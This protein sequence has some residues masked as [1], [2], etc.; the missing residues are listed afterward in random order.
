MA[1][2]KFSVAALRKVRKY[3]NN[4]LA[5]PESEQQLTSPLVNDDI[6]VPEP[7]SLDAL[8]DVF[9]FGGFDA[10]EDGEAI[11]PEGR[12]LISVVNP[13]EVLVKLPNLQL[14][15]GYR[16]VSYLFRAP[17]TG[18]GVMWAVP[19]AEGTT[20]QLEAALMAADGANRPPR[21]SMALVDVMAVV[22]GDRSPSSFLIASILKR[23]FAE[24]GAQGLA[25]DWS[26]HELIDNI[27]AR[28]ETYWRDD[29]PRDLT[30][31]IRSSSDGQ[32]VVEFFSCRTKAPVEI[33]RHIDQYPAHEDASPPYC[34][35][36]DRQVVL[37]LKSR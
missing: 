35:Q 24:F 8:G 27:P 13:A 6:E 33:V 21:P 12:W 29:Y 30:P 2:Q 28:L 7:D 4:I 31:R 3:I 1:I 20:D 5:V 19:E 22:E 9:K 17:G 26:H 14:V 11:P 25:R 18:F 15:P 34:C 32:I 37:S 23:E 10:P 36:S 16:L